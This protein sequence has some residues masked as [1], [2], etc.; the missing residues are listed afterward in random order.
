MSRCLRELQTCRRAIQA[1]NRSVQL[2]HQV[3][4][5]ENPAQ[6]PK[7]ALTAA[8]TITAH[9]TRIM[10]LLFL[11]PNEEEVCV[12]EKVGGGSEERGEM[13]GAKIECLMFENRLCRQAPVR[14]PKWRP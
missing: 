5:S 14:F 10:S 7:K 12:C 13:G 9:S 3:S 6:A 1:S 8:P 11:E 2:V 4:A